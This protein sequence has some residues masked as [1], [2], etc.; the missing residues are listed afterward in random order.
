M[1]CKYSASKYKFLVSSALKMTDICSCEN[2]KN[3]KKK[4]FFGGGVCI[5][6]HGAWC[7]IISQVVLSTY[8][9]LIWQF[10]N[11]PNSILKNPTTVKPDQEHQQRA[12]QEGSWG[13]QALL[14]LFFFFFCCNWRKQKGSDFYNLISYFLSIIM[15]GQFVYKISCLFPLLCHLVP[16]VLKG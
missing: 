14:N 2:M 8:S 15:T 3:M 10:L 7:I 4:I 13:S 6:C 5:H 9:V 16:M 11:R 12:V 1:D